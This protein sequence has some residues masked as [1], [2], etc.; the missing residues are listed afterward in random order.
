MKNDPYEKKLF[1]ENYLQNNVNLS[2]FSTKKNGAL[3]NKCFLT[4]I[5]PNRRSE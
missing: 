5:D 4:S 1:N 3:S 2:R